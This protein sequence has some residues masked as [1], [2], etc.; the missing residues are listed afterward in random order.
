MKNLLAEIW[1]KQY[2][3]EIVELIYFFNMTISRE[4]MESESNG[5]IHP[6]FSIW[7]GLAGPLV[8]SLLWAPK[9]YTAVS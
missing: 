5:I 9:A 3:R 8:V 4:F 2:R 7:R 1:L 6:K